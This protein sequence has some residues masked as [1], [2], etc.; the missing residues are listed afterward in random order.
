[1]SHHDDTNDLDVPFGEPTLPPS[2][3]TRVKA[4][5]LLAQLDGLA[6]LPSRMPPRVK[7][8]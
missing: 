5:T 4:R 3:A 1:M 7:P 2:P 6:D 8:R